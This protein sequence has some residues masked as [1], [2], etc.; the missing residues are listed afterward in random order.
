MMSK[1]A[2]SEGARKLKSNQP[3]TP[4]MVPMTSMSFVLMAPVLRAMAFG[5]VLYTVGMLFKVTRWPRLW[6]RVFS[7]H[8]LFHVLVVTAS[9]FH[10][11]VTYRF[12][13]PAAAA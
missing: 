4:T 1:A 5:G 10:W 13:L 12:V 8:E 9:V 3:T 7:S 6:P 2:Q 11:I